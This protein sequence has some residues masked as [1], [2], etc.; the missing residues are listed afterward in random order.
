[1]TPDV[2]GQ[3]SKVITMPGTARTTVIPNPNHDPTTVVEGIWP[4][5]ACT[6][7]TGDLL[8]FSGRLEGSR[9][10]YEAAVW[11]PGDPNFP[12]PADGP[13]P[14]LADVDAYRT[15][16]PAPFDNDDPEE[17]SEW[18]NADGSQAA[19]YEPGL[20]LFCCHQAHLEDGRILVMGGAGG[21]SPGDANGNPAVF[22]FDPT[23][24]VPAGGTA[25]PAG[26]YLPFWTR[27]P[28]ANQMADGRWYPTAVT[29]PDGRVVAFSGRRVAGAW[30]ND[31]TEIFSP[32]DYGAEIVTGGT[33]KFHTYPSMHMVR[34]GEIFYTHATW[35]Y[36][37]EQPAAATIDPSRLSGD[38]LPTSSFRV[39]G[40]TSGVWSDYTE[41]GSPAPL[42][43]N[44]IERKEAAAVLLAPARAGQILLVG[45]SR[46]RTEQFRDG[47]GNLQYAFN[48][49]AG[50]RIEIAAVD[51]ETTF[52][53][54]AVVGGGTLERNANG[55]SWIYKDAGGTVVSDNVGRVMREHRRRN[56]NFLFRYRSGSGN[57]DIE[58]LNFDTDP[59]PWT[60]AGGG[61]LAPRPD[62]R[63]W[64]YTDAASTVVSEFVH[65][66]VGAYFGITP[67]SE[68]RAAEILHTA[69]LPGDPTSTTPTWEDVGPT[70]NDRVNANLVLLPDGRVLVVGGE[71]EYKGAGQGFSFESEIYDPASK[72]FSPGATLGR[73][74]QYHSTALLMPDGRVYVGGGS[75]PGAGHTME[76]Y[77]P[78]YFFTE[79]SV[80]RLQILGVNAPHASERHVS[81][82]GTFEVE[83]ADPNAVASVV[84]MAPGAA[85][86]QT[87]SNQRLVQPIGVRRR[88]SATGGPGVVEVTV[89]WDASVAPP[90]WYM[91]WL[92]DQHDRPCE[93]AE[94]I[95][96][97]H[98]S[99]RVVNNRSSFGRDETKTYFDAGQPAR[100]ERALYVHVDGFLPG[101]LG[102]GATLPTG[103]AINAL[104]VSV[105]LGAGTPG[106]LVEPREVLPE[107]T[108]LDPGIR[109]RFTFVYDV[110]FTSL[111][112][113]PVASTGVDTEDVMVSVDTA[114]HQCE[115]TLRLL[116]QPNPFM[117]DGDT[118][119]LSID[120]RV[121]SIPDDEMKFGAQ[122]SG[123][124]NAYILQ[125]IDNLEL[126]QHDFE[127]LPV[128]QQDSRLALSQFDSTGRPV[129][130]FAVAQVRYRGSAGNDANDVRCFFR[131]F[132]TAV[133]NMAFDTATTYRRFPETAPTAP[134]LG[135]DGDRH[136]TTIPFFA[137][138]RVD[139]MS[140]QPD[141]TR[142]FSGTGGDTVRY[143]GCW[144]DTNQPADPRFTEQIPSL[145]D[146]G[147][148][149]AGPGNPLLTVQDLIT[150]GE[151]Q[152]LVAE[153]VFNDQVHAGDTPA[154]SDKLAQ[155]NL[156]YLPSDNP[157]S[158][159][160]R[161]IR[162]TCDFKPVLTGPVVRSLLGQPGAIGFA[163]S[164]GLTDLQ[165][166]WR[167]QLVY[168]E[169]QFQWRNIPR[170]TEVELYLP[171][172]D[173]DTMLELHRLRYGPTTLERSGPDTIRLFVE[174]ATH[175]P[176][177]GNQPIDIAALVTLR[178]PPG[179]TVGDEYTMLVEQISGVTR[180]VVGAFEIRVPVGKAV[181]ILPGLTNRFAVLKKVGATI[182]VNDRWFPVFRAYLEGVGDQVRGLGGTPELVPPDGRGWTYRPRRAVCGRMGWLTAAMLAAAL[183]LLA[184]A[185]AL[186]VAG[187]VVAAATATTWW[188][189]CR[190]GNCSLVHRLMAGGSVA[191]AAL[192][193]AA[194][195]GLR[196][197]AL[198]LALGVSAVVVVLAW[199]LATML[200]CCLTLFDRDTFSSVPDLDD[201][202]ELRSER[203]SR[204]ARER[205][206]LLANLAHQRAHLPNITG[207]AD[208]ND[209][210]HAHRPGPIDD[211]NRH[212]HGDGHG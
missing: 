169:L 87:D 204:L 158:A 124:P 128:A 116:D 190:P 80:P 66:R 208:I 170:D 205:A 96:I 37:D 125:V 117:L 49:G 132:Q 134:L 56:G 122:V 162:H 171:N 147:P 92:L 93:R 74:R 129:W 1:M 17:P 61:T 118:H 201:E 69:G 135:V 192:G 195:A 55:A 196:S 35:A 178:L 146:H 108:S 90:G 16:I 104:N 89:P 144:L 18:Y 40:P 65:R 172:A 83:V 126:P 165:R 101:E 138:P 191:A 52:P 113:F 194:I 206:E 15:A 21:Q 53:P 167:P 38:A 45:G 184:V 207:E 210:P 4:I 173:L 5:H 198:T 34:G 20:D 179:V 182:G 78:P 59:A 14:A 47:A 60:V 102:I 127:D 3:W 25:P 202:R 27:V 12:P 177:V 105:T 72:T 150:R 114:G 149:A 109:Q 181:D 176:L 139:D 88:P 97:T 84:L 133:T 42:T 63:G 70:V 212:G 2:I 48:D 137:H 13:D 166:K 51:V 155:R 115:S 120:L 23:V 103:S 112:A 81:Y 95:R 58:V 100:F 143:F 106:M 73:G 26:P 203:E 75:A 24:E 82:G 141:V 140:A 209:E 41:A 145:T 142:T 160:S 57:V 199:V 211:A 157:G 36:R 111:D 156:A 62:G 186:G 86:H 33:R 189:A 64:I 152:C 8:L 175:L 185:P 54:W 197:A 200:G 193:I 9:F 154:S 107:H 91:I 164:F 6:L 22:I 32:P 7:H 163:T 50:N 174:G 123:S 39:T 119:W 151:H 94:F 131:A 159:S 28:V 136:V 153:L 148:Y 98:R 30:I 11:T 68:P 183:I 99:C 188:R 76:F 161:T 85:T 180:S 79:P 110:G 19:S 77:K 43:P 187:L 71:V 29:L 130:N 67:A 121:F 10:R 31:D 168:D 44:Y 46:R